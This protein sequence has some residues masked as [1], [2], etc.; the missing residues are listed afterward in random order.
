MRHP[1]HNRGK[2][3]LEIVIV[4]SYNGRSSFQFL[5]G[6]FRVVCTNGL[7]AGETFDTIKVKHIGL[8]QDDVIEASY[9][10]LETAPR[11]AGAIDTMKSIELNRGEKH[12]FA[13]SALQLMYDE[14]ANESPI[15]AA[16]LLVPRRTDDTRSDLW[17]TFNVVQENV[18]RGGIKGR[19]VKSGRR[20]TTRP[21]K[22]IDRDVKLGRALW[23]LT[24]EM[25]KL[26]A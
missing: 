24:E 16:D 14:P 19:S 2:E 1:K 12:V 11:I 8:T 25:A 20:I 10:V 21:V 18:T 22:S 3:F 26:K 17:T 6:I 15:S 4:N 23:T 13:R 7:I 5:V 9:K